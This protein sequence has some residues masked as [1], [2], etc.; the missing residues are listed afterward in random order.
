M[1]DDGLV[2]AVRLGCCVCCV[3][4]GSMSAEC[5]YKGGPF[6]EDLIFQFIRTLQSRD[7]WVY[8][9]GQVAADPL[10]V[11]RVCYSRDHL[12]DVVICEGPVVS[13]SYQRVG[14]CLAFEAG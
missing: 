11:L 7:L 12:C 1:E 10:V 8:R 14:C 3:G 6:V 13:P 9:G 5:Y 4:V 2:H